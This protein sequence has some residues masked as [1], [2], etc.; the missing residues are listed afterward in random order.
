MNWLKFLQIILLICVAG[1]V[2]YFVVPKYE[3]Y[4]S[5][6]DGTINYRFNTITGMLQNDCL[7]KWSNNPMYPIKKT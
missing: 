1:L 7:K 4:Q 5:D 2:F 3:L 6:G